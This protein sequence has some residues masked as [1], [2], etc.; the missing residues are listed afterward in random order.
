M[1]LRQATRGNAIPQK[2][3]QPVKTIIPPQ[4]TMAQNSKHLAAQESASPQKTIQS[5]HVGP[6]SSVVIVD[7]RPAPTS[8]NAPATK[9]DLDKDFNVLEKASQAPDAP[10][11]GSVKVE[12]GKP[13]K[14]TILEKYDRLK[15]EE[16][17]S[18]DLELPDLM[19]VD[20]PPSVSTNR[21][22]DAEDVPSSL[23]AP[24]VPSHSSR[25]KPTAPF[26]DEDLLQFP[27]TEDL[28]STGPIEVRGQ[29]ATFPKTVNIVNAGI[30]VSIEITS[31][32]GPNPR[33]ETAKNAEKMI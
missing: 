2:A 18:G 1:K 13:E 17:A 29:P 11:A 31:R 25:Q 22:F 9:T 6:N 14:L 4:K 26:E 19:D 16:E 7:P 15:A 32:P 12:R 21:F 23:P 8:N 3:S 30:T 28:S 20:S 24:L 5:T 10:P 27:E 33:R